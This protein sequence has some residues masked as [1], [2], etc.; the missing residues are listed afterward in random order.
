MNPGIFAKHALD[1]VARYRN[2][3]LLNGNPFAGIMKTSLHY[4]CPNLHAV[5]VKPSVAYPMT[6][7]IIHVTPALNHD[8]VRD[9]RSIHLFENSWARVRGYRNPL[10]QIEISLR[11]E[12]GLY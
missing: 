5:V 10:V 3:F 7:P 6:P 1:F 4:R 9:D 12:F 11:K 8:C 2:W